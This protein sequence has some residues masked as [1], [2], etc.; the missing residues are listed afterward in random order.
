MEQSEQFIR[1]VLQDPLWL[2]MAN[3]D[4]E[5]MMTYQLPSR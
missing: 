2:I 4:E 1:C 5:V 3:T